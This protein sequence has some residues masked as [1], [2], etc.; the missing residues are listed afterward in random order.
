MEQAIMKDSYILRSFYPVI[1]W[2]INIFAL[3]VFFKG[4]NAPGGGFIAGIA[5][6]ISLVFL[7]II[8]GRKCLNRIPSPVSLAAIGLALA[9]GTALAPTLMG[10][11]F[12]MHT[13]WH[14]HIP[15]LGELHIGT[16]ALFD[17]GVYCVV[18]GIT[19]SIALWFDE[20]SEYE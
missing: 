15:L 17:L 6:A 5:S 12:L 3:F 19:V 18:I 8:E 14:L 1:F 10:Q 16:P 11:A 13:M 7:Y 4:H 20:A 9:Y 2:I